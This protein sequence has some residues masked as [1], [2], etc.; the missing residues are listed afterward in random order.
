MNGQTRMQIAQSEAILA[1][2]EKHFS[3]SEVH[4]FTPFIAETLAVSV[5][6]SP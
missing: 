5:D 3:A 1:Q 2:K 6:G 4:F